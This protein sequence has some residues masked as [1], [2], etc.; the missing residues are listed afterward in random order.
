MRRRDI[1]S[2]I[3][4]VFSAAHVERLK[5]RAR[6]EVALR[7]RDQRPQAAQPL[8]EAAHKVPDPNQ[9]GG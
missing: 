2:G 6:R 9:K 5:E 3:A 1:V 4:S 7:A 8:S